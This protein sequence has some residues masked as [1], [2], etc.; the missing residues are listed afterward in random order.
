M[1]IQNNIPL[2]NLT[3]IGLGGKAQYFVACES[4][5]EIQEALAY[6]KEH[7]LD[8]HV[9]GGGSN[10]V[11]PDHDFEK[12]VLKISLKGVEYAEGDGYVDVTA[13][14]GE[15]WDSLVSAC[16][17]KGLAGIETLSGIPGS[18]GATPIQNVGAYGSEVADV[19]VAVATLDI[20]ANEIRHFENEEC[21][22]GYRTSRFKTTDKGKYIVTGVTYRLTP[23]GEPKIT[24][25]EL[26]ATVGENVGSGV[27]ALIKVRETVLALRR[28]KSMV[29]DP[30][31]PDSRSCG[32]FFTNPLVS[33]EQLVAI[34]EKYPEVPHFSSGQK[35][36][37]LAAWLIEH[38][39]WK[40]GQEYKGIHI[41]NKHA[42]A[43]VST[44]QGNAEDL[45][46]FARQIQ[47]SVKEKFGIALQCE[48]EVIENTHVL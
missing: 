2:A 16:V 3:T 7:N 26:A 11:F 31:D 22:F 12:L 5:A 23:N 1:E 47:E 39:G 27:D 41:S 9:L 42:L 44:E 32:S 8:V 30:N 10:T 45:L 36:K 38:A 37:I 18:V 13:A 17:A 6:A 43:L 28:K 40:K 15:D 24:Y 29:L 46:A 21:A 25:P 14:A 20:E 19:I 35:E 48:P 33:P 4:I 34:Q